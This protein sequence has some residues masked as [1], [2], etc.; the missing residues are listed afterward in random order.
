MY[1]EYKEEYFHIL[2]SSIDLGNKLNLEV[3]KCVMQKSNQNKYVKT[4]E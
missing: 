4:S 2:F 3:V 1:A